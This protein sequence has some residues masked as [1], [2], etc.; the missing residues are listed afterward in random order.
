[1]VSAVNRLRAIAALAAAWFLLW[2]GFWLV[3]FSL[4]AVFDPGSLDPGEPAAFARVFTLLGLA[5]AVVW[6]VCESAA[7]R[8]AGAAHPGI[9]RAVLWGAF[10]GVLPVVAVGKIQQAAVLGPVGAA[11]GATLAIVARGASA[12][13]GRGWLAAA[14]FLRRAFL[15]TAG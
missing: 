11:I 14:R 15:P 12:G 10:A 2:A 7:P 5:S 6:G 3:F 8:P 1:M 13:G 4:V 9:V